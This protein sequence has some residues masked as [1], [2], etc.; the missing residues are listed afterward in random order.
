MR[1]DDGRMLWSYPSNAMKHISAEEFKTNCLALINQVKA[2]GEP[3]LITE[4]GKPVAKLLPAATKDD[5]IF[6]YM[7]GRAKI[8]GDIVSSITPIEDWDALK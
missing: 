1:S 8:V 4:H 5:S 6:G 2:T 7:A 3:I